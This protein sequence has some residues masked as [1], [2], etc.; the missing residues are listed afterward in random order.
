MICSFSLQTHPKYVQGR[1]VLVYFATFAFWETDPGFIDFNEQVHLPL[2]S[3]IDDLNSL[4]RIYNVVIRPHPLTP[5]RYIAGGSSMEERFP[6]A[7]LDVPQLGFHFLDAAREADVIVAEPGSVAHA[8]LVVTASKPWVYLLKQ[9]SLYE[10][11]FDVLL[12]EEMAA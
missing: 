3:V 5:A 1:P 6:R 7:I 11:C 9:R 4:S 10:K 2:V 8:A 12:N